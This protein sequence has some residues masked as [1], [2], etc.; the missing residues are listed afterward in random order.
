MIPRSL[1]LVA[2]RWWLAG[3]EA[4]MGLTGQFAE[5]L[6]LVHAVLEG[7]PAVDKD[8]RNFIGE[9]APQ[10]VVAIH[11]HFFPMETAPALKL[12]QSLFDDFAQMTAFSRVDHNLSRG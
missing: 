12:Y 8:H 11:V 9:L 1:W 2:S 7:L 3:K 5:K 4:E 6:A 10:R